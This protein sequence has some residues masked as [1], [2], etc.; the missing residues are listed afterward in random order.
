MP[1]APALAEDAAFTYQLSGAVG[2]A[3]GGGAAMHDRPAVLP[4]LAVTALR[5]A[6]RAHPGQEENTHCMLETLETGK[7]HCWVLL[8]R[9]D[10]LFSWC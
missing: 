9:W 1:A 4:N 7:S 6:G 5:P 10:C 2:L 8:L 3:E